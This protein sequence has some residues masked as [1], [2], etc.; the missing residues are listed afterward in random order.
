MIS[1]VKK[2]KVGT[3]VEMYDHLHYTFG[4]KKK[5]IKMAARPQLHYCNAEVEHKRALL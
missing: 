1:I 5:K 4:L 3:C 2:K